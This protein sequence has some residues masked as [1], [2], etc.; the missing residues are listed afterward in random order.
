MTRQS[1][2][3]LLLALY[4]LLVPLGAGCG[5]HSQDKPQPIEET[6]PQPP[7][8]TPSVATQP[9]PEPTSTTSPPATSIPP[10]SEP[11]TP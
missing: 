2:T 1:L 5:V 7:P 11:R 10:Q 9:A 4:L 6:S 3:A 8:A